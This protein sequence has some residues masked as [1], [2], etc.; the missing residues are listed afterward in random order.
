MIRGID[1]GILVAAEIIGH[2]DYHATQ[3]L[4]AER[5]AAGDTLAIAPQVLSEFMHVVTDTRR[6]ERP[7]DMVEARRIA[8]RWWTARMVTQVFPNGEAMQLFFVWVGQHRLGRKRVLDT[9]LAATYQRAG[10]YSILT[11][12]PHDFEVLEGVTYL[13]PRSA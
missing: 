1:T 2:P 6:F 9:L 11:T 13:V 7:F 3:I 8:M 5:L 10:I 12:N 4:L